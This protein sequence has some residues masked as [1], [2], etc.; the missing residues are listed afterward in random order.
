MPGAGIAGDVVLLLLD[1]TNLAGARTL[2]RFLLC[3]FDALAFPQQLEHSTSNGA[4]VKEVFDSALIAN[5]P[6]A[7]VDEET[8]DRPGRHTRVLRSTNPWE[9]SQ[10]L[11]QQAP[12]RQ[13][14]IPTRATGHMAAPQRDD[15]LEIGAS[16]EISQ[17]EVKR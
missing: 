17:Q 16:V 5:E 9:K 13:H 6:K 14:S 15:E 7:L 12:R 3:E 2:R 10:S 8:R 1:Q 4:P 11:S